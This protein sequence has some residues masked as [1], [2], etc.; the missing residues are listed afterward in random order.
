MR[1]LFLGLLMLLG[2]A[3]AARVPERP[4]NIIV[5]LADDLG[6]GDIG[7]NGSTLTRTPALD[8]MAAEGVRL[9]DFYASA[10]VCTPSRAALMTGRYAIR[11]GLAKG[12]IHP[13]S[14]HGL[15][16]GE[17]TIAEMLKAR[18]YRTALIGKWHLG[19]RPE[20]HPLRQGFDEF[21]GLPYSNDMAPLA[22]YE[23]E[24]KVEEP[25]DQVTLTRRY[26]DRAIAIVQAKDDRPFFVT[27]AHSMPHIPLFAGPG[28]A[29]KSPAGLY[30][31]VVEELDWN[32]GR[33][34]DALRASG[35][36]RETLVIFT[37]DNG[38][39]YEGST[40][41]LRG[42]KGNSWEGGYRVPFLARWPGHLKAGTRSAAP[43]AMIDLLPTLAAVAGAKAPQDR[44]IDGRDIWPVL[45]DGAPSPHDSIVFFD[46][47]YIAAIRSGDWRMVV[48]DY[49]RTLDL[50]LDQFG[51]YFL[52]NLRRDPSESYN[53]AANEPEAL[54][55]MKAKL[56]AARAALNVPPRPR[57]GL[58]T[59][60]TDVRK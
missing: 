40:G 11:S 47:E 22:L 50:P 10:N 39:W 25:V 6:Y 4:P 37:S 41:G 45:A 8:R 7:A 24:R 34:L 1:A 32:T 33:L 16:P 29:G 28:F 5:I 31:D 23:G 20:F 58:P 60:V 12:V 17:V 38:P 13:P 43:V 2:P 48:Q 52:F 57:Y 26:T 49:Y 55:A 30:G 36:D 18:G 46:N 56:D 59:D 42:R 14:T 15:P 44:P 35:K 53:F 9:T 3:A 21:F 54:A 51:A 27:L 19:H